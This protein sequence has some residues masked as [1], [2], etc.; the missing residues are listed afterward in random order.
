MGS[1]KNFEDAMN[2]IRDLGDTD[3]NSIFDWW[4]KTLPICP[5]SL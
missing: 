1:K 4:L 2:H 3:L 5:I